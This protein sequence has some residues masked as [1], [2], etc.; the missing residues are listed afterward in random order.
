MF[1]RPS[2][3]LGGGE[4]VSPSFSS[5]VRVIILKKKAR[6]RDGWL[7]VS[8]DSFAIPV[9]SKREHLLWSGVAI[10]ARPLLSCSSVKQVRRRPLEGEQNPHGYVALFED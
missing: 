4:A 7:G 1:S 3:V 10:P 5:Q 6:Q 2:Q 9:R 8:G